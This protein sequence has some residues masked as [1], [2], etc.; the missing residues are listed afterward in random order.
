MNYAGTDTKWKVTTSFHDFQLTEDYFEIVIK[1][2]WGR[3]VRTVTKSDCFW[4]KDGNFYFTLENMAEG[5]YKACFRG[6][7]ED[8]DYDKQTQAVADEQELCKVR[9]C[10]GSCGCSIFVPEC[11][12]KHQVKYEQVFEVSIDGED[13]LADKDGRYIL[14]SDGK[15]ICFKNDKAQTIEDMGKVRLDTM[16]GDEFKQFIEGRTP[17]GRIDTVPELMDAM[18]GI[19]DEETVKDDVNEQI[20]DKH[21][22]SSD[23]DEIL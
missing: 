19:S 1:N 23:I 17:N 20:D 21:A 2:S 7:T 5:V 10:D 9:V 3:I 4:D 11:K 16:T 22:N 8:E 12:C 18:R 13:Y 6:W 15:R 14:T